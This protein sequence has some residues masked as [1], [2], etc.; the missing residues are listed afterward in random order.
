MRPSNAVERGLDRR[1]RPVRRAE[2]GG[3]DDRVV[4]EVGGGRAPS[5]SADAG[6]ERDPGA[7]G[8]ERH[9][10]GRADAAGRHR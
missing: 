1:A 5:W 3:D 7:G 6:D 10:D 4:D 8:V 9:G 2:V